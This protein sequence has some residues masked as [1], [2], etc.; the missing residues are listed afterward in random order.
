M[1]SPSTEIATVATDNTIK[2]K[3]GTLNKFCGATC[4]KMPANTPAV[5]KPPNTP[6]QVLPGETF[7]ASLCLPN[8]RPAKY[9]PNRL[10][11]QE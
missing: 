2:G 5:T 1:R 7:G 11:K 8:F 9:A 3:V 6:C 4:I 10:P